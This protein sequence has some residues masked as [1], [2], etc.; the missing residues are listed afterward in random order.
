MICTKLM[1]QLSKFC[2]PDQTVILFFESGL[3]FKSS[4]NTG[5]FESTN[6]LEPECIDFIEFYDCSFEVSEILQLPFKDGTEVKQGS[7]LAISEYGEPHKIETENKS[8]IW[9][10]SS[11]Q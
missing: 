6:N 10:E 4:K 2:R 9:Q 8:I 5:V 7:Y 1:E 3:V 11:T